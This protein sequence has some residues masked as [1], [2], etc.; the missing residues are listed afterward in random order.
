MAI[1]IPQTQTILLSYFQTNDVPTED[2]FKELIGTM[3]Y[4]YNDMVNRATA[5]EDTA[6]EALA[7]VESLCPTAVARGNYAG[8]AANFNGTHTGVASIAAIDP[9]SGLVIRFTFTTPF[10][11]TNYKTVYSGAN[12]GIVNRN[13]AYVDFGF[14][15]G[16]TA[17]QFTV[18]FAA[19]A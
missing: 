9:G 17:T 10:A 3:F 8:N 13:V 1:V 5:A 18:T 7:L 16:L 15:I 6:N 11:N 19:W 14:P 2:Q 4:L 12:S